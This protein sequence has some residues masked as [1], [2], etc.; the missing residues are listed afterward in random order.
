MNMLLV[1]S[2]TRG[3]ELCSQIVVYSEVEVHTQT[4]HSNLQKYTREF[5]ASR[6]FFASVKK[7]QIIIMG[8]ELYEWLEMI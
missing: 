5:N 4:R 7:Y 6:Q 8:E 3:L 2:S 1:E